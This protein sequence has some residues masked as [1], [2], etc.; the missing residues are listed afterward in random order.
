[1]FGEYF[2]SSKSMLVTLVV[3]SPYSNLNTSIPPDSTLSPFLPQ[4]LTMSVFLIYCAAIFLFFQNRNIVNKAFISPAPFCEL[5]FP[6]NRPYSILLG[7][8]FL[9]NMLWKQL[10]LNKGWLVLCQFTLEVSFNKCKHVNVHIT[11]DHSVYM[12]P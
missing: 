6:T 12:S 11:T 5:F 10:Y 7:F 2:A 9:L 8:F 1:M 4:L 3:P